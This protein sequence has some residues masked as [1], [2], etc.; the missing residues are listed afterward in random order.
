M[1][2]IKKVALLRE[3][4]MMKPAA[5]LR[6]LFSNYFVIRKEGFYSNIFFQIHNIGY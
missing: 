6:G 3:A 2:F 5:K 1:D 4:S